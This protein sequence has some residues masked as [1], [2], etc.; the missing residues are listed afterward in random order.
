MRQSSY[1][2]GVSVAVIVGLFALRPAHAAEARTITFP[3][4]GSVRY[5]ND[6]G[7]PRSGHTHEGNDL[8][9]KKGQLLVAAVTGTVR[10]VPYPQPSYG[11]YVSISDDE[12]YEYNYLHINNDTPGTDDGQGGAAHA[13]AFGMERSWPVKA[14]QLIGYMGDSGNAEGT[15]PHL[16]FEIRTPDGEAINPFTSL[17]AAQHIL[18]PSQRALREG[19]FIPFPSETVGSTIAAGQIFPDTAESE[20]VAGSGPGGRPR[21]RVFQPNGLR[22]RTLPVF[23][24]EFKG[25]LDV[26]TGDMN[27]DGT[28]EIIVGFGKGE[29]PRVQI[30]NGDGVILKEFLAY[31]EK[32]RGGVNVSAADLNGDGIDE[33]VTGAGAG[34]GP[35]VRVF[36]GDGEYQW[37]FY[38]YTTRFYGGVDVAAIDATSTAPGK[39]ITGPGPNGGPELRLFDRDGNMLMAAFAYD[40]TFR[41][42]IRVAELPP[43]TVFDDSSIMVIPANGATARYR[44]FSLDGTLQ[45]EESVFERWW[46]GGYDVTSVDGVPYASTGRNRPSVIIPVDT[47]SGRNFFSDENL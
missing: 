6:F 24:A 5:S 30:L 2:L 23:P 14:G 27:G 45:D 40:K 16:H 10:F 29:K 26:A 34:G 7:A 18:A 42:G 19:E 3:V 21:V 25:G 1:K 41:G 39:I 28:D 46:L 17:N 47:N 37:N 22:L 4:V 9:G 35:D 38:A 33:I 13:Y 11:W 15:S 36:N 20:I 8:L 32:F 12:G 31:K 43:Q 44:E